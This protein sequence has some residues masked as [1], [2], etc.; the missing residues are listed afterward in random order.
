MQGKATIAGRPVHP[1]CDCDD[2]QELLLS[3][4][5]SH[6]YKLLQERILGADDSGDESA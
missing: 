1:H 4:G 3:K 5:Q 2:A 6:L